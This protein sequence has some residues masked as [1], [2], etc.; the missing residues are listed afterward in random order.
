M[1]H[2]T[3]HQTGSKQSLVSVGGDVGS[4]SGVA[5]EPDSQTWLEDFG[6]EL[7]AVSIDRHTHSEPVAA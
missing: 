4:G 5:V 3:D 7:S 2:Q 6:H 1:G